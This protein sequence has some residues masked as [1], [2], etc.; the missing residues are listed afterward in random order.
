MSETYRDDTTE[1]AVASDTT[2]LGL[3]GTVIEELATISAV[4]LVT[5]GTLTLDSA[6]VGDEVLSHTT[7]A[8]TTETAAAGDEALGHLNAV[9]LASETVRVSESLRLSLIHI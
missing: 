9:Q 6:T 7:R 2:W 5:I 4:A 1:L 8:T 3:T